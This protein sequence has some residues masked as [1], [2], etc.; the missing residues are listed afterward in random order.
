MH[1]NHLGLRRVLDS[2][3]ATKTAADEP[4]GDGMEL[5]PRVARIVPT[6]IF[7][8]P[9]VAVWNLVLTNDG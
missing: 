8:G 6:V 9:V 2:S 1:V 5:E 3:T 7:I 4:S